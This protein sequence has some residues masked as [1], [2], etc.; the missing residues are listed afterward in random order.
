MPIK[1]SVTRK[2][3]ERRDVRFPP[4]KKVTIAAFEIAAF[5]HDGS[6]ESDLSWDMLCDDMLIALD[7]WRAACG[8]EKLAPRNKAAP[9]P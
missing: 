7:E 3:V 5:V 9:S 1:D 2:E 4:A 6:E 8:M